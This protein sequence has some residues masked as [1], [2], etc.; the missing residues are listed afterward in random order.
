MSRNARRSFGIQHYCWLCINPKEAEDMK[1]AD[2]VIA[3]DPGVPEEA[4]RA[5]HRRDR[6]EQEQPQ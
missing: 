3:L 6:P 4:Q 5:R 2:D 1:L